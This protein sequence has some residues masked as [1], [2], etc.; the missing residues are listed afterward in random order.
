MG[1]FDSKRR[2][3]I[4]VRRVWKPMRRLVVQCPKDG[5]AMNVSRPDVETVGHSL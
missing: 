4:V 1:G 2:L 5:L 3:V